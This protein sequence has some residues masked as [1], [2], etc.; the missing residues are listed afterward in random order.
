ML[1]SSHNDNDKIIIKIIK[2]IV[3]TLANQSSLALFP[4]HG[5]LCIETPDRPS[6]S[7]MAPHHLLLPP[8][9]LPPCGLL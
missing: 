4:S 3:I 7:S 9:E 1:S 2:I 5:K 8:Y 6:A